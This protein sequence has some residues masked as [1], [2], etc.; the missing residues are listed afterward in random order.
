MRKYTAE[1]LGTFILTFVCCGGASFTGGYQQGFL[2]TAG[3]SM[4][5]G[6]VL[7]ALCY[8]VG[9]VSG[10][11][12]NPAVSIA[13]LAAG[14]MSIKD[15]IGYIAAQ[16]AGGI[17]AGFALFGIGHTFNPVVLSQ[18]SKTSADFLSLG[19]N[20]YGTNGGF[21]Q[22]S[23]EGAVLVEFILTFI[24]VYTVLGV[25]SRPEYKSVSGIVIGGA[26]ASVHLFG[27]S[28]T[29]TGVNPARS[30]GPALV[31]GICLDDYTA[32]S[33]VWVFIAAPLLGGL[34]AAIVYMFLNETKKKLKEQ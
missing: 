2:Q 4:L 16:F 17:A 12:V 19:T 27:V 14:K 30:L 29:G 21:L 3:I 6:L 23:A 9:N 31:K 34:A 32:L 10:C 24:F 25:T 13:M 28:L 7:T 26:L 18:Y 33:Q 20:G 1:F 8:S 5:F 15:F 11:H 22:I